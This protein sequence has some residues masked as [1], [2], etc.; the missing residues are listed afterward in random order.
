QK[1]KAKVELRNQADAIVYQT[2][3]TLSDNQEK[4]D[5]TLKER[6]ESELDQLDGLINKDGT[7]I[8]MNDLDE[9]AIQSKI[10]EL[11]SMMY[12]FS[13]AIYEQAQAEGA[14]PTPSSEDDVVDAD[15]EIVDEEE[16]D[17]AS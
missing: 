16:K 3:K 12:E 14:A 10:S 8:D 5:S 2:R 4:V 7:P 11:E 13:E 6:L 15:F 9:A 1:R 17:E